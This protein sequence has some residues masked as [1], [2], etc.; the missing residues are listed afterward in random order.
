MGNLKV[1]LA[2]GTPSQINRQIQKESELDRTRLERT[3]AQEKSKMQA[4]LLKNVQAGSGPGQ[5]EERE[6]EMK[7]LIVENNIQRDI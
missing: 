1:L 7:T 3:L 4:Q 6:K 5:K 2:I